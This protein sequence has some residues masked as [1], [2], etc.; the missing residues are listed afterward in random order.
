MADTSTPKWLDTAAKKRETRDA[1]IRKFLEH[2][3]VSSA[4]N[5]DNVDAI[6][7]AISSGA[8]TAEKLCTSYICR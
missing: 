3:H 8:V 4:V 7:R 6:P 1:T 2:C 5:I